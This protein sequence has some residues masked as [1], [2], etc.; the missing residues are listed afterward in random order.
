[1][2]DAGGNPWPANGQGIQL[3]LRRNGASNPPFT[4]AAR[5]V[6]DTTPWSA[7][8]ATVTRSATTASLNSFAPGSLWFGVLGKG[9]GDNSGAPPAGMAMFDNFRFAVSVP[10]MP[11]T[12]LYG[13]A[14]V[15]YSGPAAISNVSV[16]VPGSNTSAMLRGLSANFPYTV[17]VYAQ[18]AATGMWSIPSAP[19]MGT[20]LWARRLPPRQQALSLFLDS[21]WMPGTR[22]NNWPDASGRG[23]SM[24]GRSAATQPTGIR[25]GGYGGDFLTPGYVRFTRS[26]GTF[27]VGDA[28]AIDLGVGGEMTGYWIARNRETATQIYMG[29]GTMAAT[30]DYSP[31]WMLAVQSTATDTLSGFLSLRANDDAGTIAGGQVR[32]VIQVTWGYQ[33]STPLTFGVVRNTSAP[34]MTGSLGGAH[35]LYA[36]NEPTCTNGSPR[37]FEDAN[38]ASYPG[39]NSIGSKVSVQYRL[40]PAGGV[41][42]ARPPISDDNNFRIGGQPSSV[43]NPALAYGG[44]IYGIMLYREAHDRATRTQ[45]SEWYRSYIEASYC[46]LNINSVGV[47]AASQ[48]ATGPIWA[49]CYQECSSGYSYFLGSPRYHGCS[50]GIWGSPALVCKRM[51]FDVAPPAYVQSCFRRYIDETFDGSDPETVARPP[52][53]KYVTHPLIPAFERNVIWVWDRTMGYM[54][55]NT[56]TAD[57][58]AR[59][60]TGESILGPH[61]TRWSLYNPPNNGLETRTSAT[62]RLDSSASIAG[63]VVRLVDANQHYRAEFSTGNVTLVRINARSGTPSFTRTVLRTVSGGNATIMAGV[64]Y[65][66][67]VRAKRSAFSVLLNDVVIITATDATNSPNYGSGGVYIG[68]GSMATFDAMSIDNECDLG[69]VAR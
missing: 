52:S 57:A 5:L 53:A 4:M 3:Y 2:M 27:M 39:T 6:G 30:M 17:T 22:I 50:N 54:V 43:G 21:K 66:V 49:D 33:T 11:P 9:S 32:N 24:L 31:G 44:D 67:S 47:P 25:N 59:I 8:P 14:D 23:H 69:N 16:T 10:S 18:E 38:N 62:M 61:V 34:P 41:A 48:C 51:C 40:D 35:S 26:A 37:V 29:R 28:D 19:I 64:W 60:R 63:V 36:C 55:A 45:I 56:A 65:N 46:P 68:S 58:C 42:I 1:M 7:L 20:Y 15:C 12:D 13:A